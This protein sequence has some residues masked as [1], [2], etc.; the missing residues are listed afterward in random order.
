MQIRIIVVLKQFSQV[1]KVIK[2]M[3]RLSVIYTRLAVVLA[4]SVFVKTCFGQAKAKSVVA[5]RLIFHM[6]ETRLRSRKRRRRR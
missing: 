1:I 4:A 5:S 2:I 6:I 3:H